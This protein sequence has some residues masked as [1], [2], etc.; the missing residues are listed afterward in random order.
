MDNVEGILKI[1]KRFLKENGVYTRAM[2]LHLN[3]CGRKSRK[4]TP[5]KFK[6]KL[7]YFS[8]PMCLLS[9][10]GIFCIWRES[11]EGDYFWW[12]ISN[13]WKIKC[14]NECIGITP[15]WRDYNHIIKVIDLYL[16]SFATTMPKDERIE[17]EKIRL[18]FMKKI[19]KA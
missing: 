7:S 2:Y 13:K 4:I 16:A 5:E 14:I 3:G 18:L 17:T 1:Y 9:N 12:K 15:A 19:K 6:N 11:S 10:V 8:D